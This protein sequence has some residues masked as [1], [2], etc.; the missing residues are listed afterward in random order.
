MTTTLEHD[1]SVRIEADNAQDLSLRLEDAISSFV[2]GALELGDRGILVTRLSPLEYLV[3]LDPS[4]PF[5][6][7]REHCAWDRF[8]DR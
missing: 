2:P 5:G 4:V 8:E 7:T 3:A 1:Y 6:T